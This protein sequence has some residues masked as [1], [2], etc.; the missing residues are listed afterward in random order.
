MRPQ[1]RRELRI[2]VRGI[3]GSLQSPGDVRVVD[4]S[5]HGVSFE[6]LHKLTVGDDCFLELRYRNKVVSVATVL[7]WCSLTSASNPEEIRAFRAGGA[8]TEVLADGPDGLW[9]CLVAESP[10]PAAPEHHG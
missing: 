5:R 1:R 10:T 3:E 7:R 4:L 9:S 8:F 6:T 2:P